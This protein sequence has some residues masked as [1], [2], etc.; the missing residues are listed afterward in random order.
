MRA[1]V[2]DFVDGRFATAE[3]FLAMADKHG[4]TVMPVLFDDYFVSAFV[5]EPDHDV[6][7]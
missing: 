5:V 7:G 3:L 6:L 1:Y 4:I 2:R